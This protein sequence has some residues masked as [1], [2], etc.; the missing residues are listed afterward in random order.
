MRALRLLP[1]TPVLDILRTYIS[2]TRR[3]IEV[4]HIVLAGDKHTLVYQRATPIPS[5]RRIDPPARR[6]LRRTLQPGGG[7][8]P[9]ASGSCASR[10][11]PH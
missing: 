7:P 1:G 3:P 8:Q 4:M 10:R 9:S 5:R 2:I 6:A 11:R